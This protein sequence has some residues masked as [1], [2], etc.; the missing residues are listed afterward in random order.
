MIITTIGTAVLGAV[1]AN[2][3]GIGSETDLTPKGKKRSGPTQW[4]LFIL[5]FWIGGFPAYLYWRSKYGLKNLVVGGIFIALLFIGV[6]GGMSVLIEN[7]KAA[8]RE[9][10]SGFTR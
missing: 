2:Q 1:E 10:F 4:F 7:Q 3:L 5:L 9:Q 8:I 6:A